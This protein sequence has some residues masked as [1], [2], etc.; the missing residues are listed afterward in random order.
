MRTSGVLATAE[1]LMADY[2]K[3]TNNK[4]SLP[5]SLPRRSVYSRRYKMSGIRA[6]KALRI[7]KTFQSKQLESKA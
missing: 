1:Q 5:W 3:A 7:E 2:N 4:Q 6:Y